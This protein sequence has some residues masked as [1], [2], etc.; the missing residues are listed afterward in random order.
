MLADGPW[1][2]LSFQIIVPELSSVAALV[3]GVGMA[4]IVLH[5]RC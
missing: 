1:T 3:A 5:R 4:V 2:G